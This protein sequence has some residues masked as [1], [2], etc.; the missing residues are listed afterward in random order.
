M[1]T[2]FNSLT[3]KDKLAFLHLFKD[4]ASDGIEEAGSCLIELD[5][6]VSESELTLIFKDLGWPD[7]YIEKLALLA[8]NHFTL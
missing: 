3:L 5:V 4:A 7:R 8:P 6:V 2:S 1:R